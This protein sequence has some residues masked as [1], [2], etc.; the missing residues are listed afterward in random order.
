MSFQ[1]AVAAAW[2]LYLVFFFLFF[3]GRYSTTADCGGQRGCCQLLCKLHTRLWLS[4][5]LSQPSA[6]PAGGQYYHWAEVMPTGKMCANFCIF[7]WHFKLYSE[8]KLLVTLNNCRVLAYV[9]I[10]TRRPGNFKMLYILFHCLFF[11]IVAQHFVLTF[12]QYHEILLL[13][14]MADLSGCQT[15]ISQPIS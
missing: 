7:L 10:W 12:K 13:A 4:F 15:L 14:L 2:F 11:F 8:A 5:A 1:L 9:F 6:E 3:S